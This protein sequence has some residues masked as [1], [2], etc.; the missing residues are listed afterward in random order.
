MSLKVFIISYCQCETSDE[1]QIIKDGTEPSPSRSYKEQM[2]AQLSFDN[3]IPSTA[4]FTTYI[5]EFVVVVTTLL[6][7]I[8][9]II[10]NFNDVI[11]IVLVE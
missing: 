7:L 1:G 2:H 9:I 6:I 8:P 5:V 10:T 4:T 3:I 11:I